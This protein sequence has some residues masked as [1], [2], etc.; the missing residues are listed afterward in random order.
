[1]SVLA[2]LLVLA[3]DFGDH[4][5]NGWWIVMLLFWGLVALAAVWAVRSF[6]GHRREVGADT[7]PMEVLDRRLADGSVSIEEY[8]QRRRV[9]LGEQ[10]QEGS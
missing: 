1:M 7:T 2:A 6:A 9:L 4:M 10:G 3:D 8:E 5:D